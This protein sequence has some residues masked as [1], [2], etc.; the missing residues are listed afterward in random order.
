MKRLAPSGPSLC[1]LIPGGEQP[2]DGTV[3][4]ETAAEVTLLEVVV[5]LVAAEDEP[6]R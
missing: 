1:L 2:P 3:E 6:R 5:L 4:A